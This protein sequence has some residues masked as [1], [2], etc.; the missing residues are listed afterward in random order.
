MN[1]TLWVGGSATIITVL[2]AVYAVCCR[3]A[4]TAKAASTKRYERIVQDADGTYRTISAGLPYRPD[5]HNPYAYKEYGPLKINLSFVD[6]A[7][8]KFCQITFSVFYDHDRG[9]EHYRYKALGAWVDKCDSDKWYRSDLEEALKRTLR[10][11]LNCTVAN[12]TEK[13]H[14][15]QG[16]SYTY[17]RLTAEVNSALRPLDAS[18]TRTKPWHL[19]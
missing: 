1:M 19:S 10:E 17:D 12:F 13:R 6:P 2:C 3:K 9:V 15:M 16:G 4:R 7:T 14:D 8:K 5:P 11:R 18:L